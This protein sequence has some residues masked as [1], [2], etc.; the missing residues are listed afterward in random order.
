MKDKRME[1]N[2]PRLGFGEQ[3]VWN[4]SIGD[5]HTHFFKKLTQ[6]RIHENVRLR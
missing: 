1:E 2:K 3:S 4:K 6:V 5:T